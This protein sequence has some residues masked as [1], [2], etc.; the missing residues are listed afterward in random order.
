MFAKWWI[1]TCHAFP[2][3]TNV[4]SQEK[5]TIPGIDKSDLSSYWMYTGSQQMFLDAL[6][7]GSFST[8]AL[9]EFNHPSSRLAPRT[10][11]CRSC[12][13]QLWQ[14]WRWLSLQHRCEHWSRA[15]HNDW[16]R[17]WPTWMPRILQVPG[18]KHLQTKSRMRC[19]LCRSVS[20]LDE[21]LTIWFDNLAIW[22]Y[23]VLYFCYFV[24][25]CLAIDALLQRGKL[26][27]YTMSTY[28]TVRNLCSIWEAG[29]RVDEE[30]FM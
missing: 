23:L 13:L 20:R 9:P 3:G 12:H 16:W 30:F 17:W 27:S 8:Q 15:W 19:N 6:R 2:R 14:R 4:M 7:V 24:L 21:F 1:K 11:S 26:G 5:T 28:E 25:T 22:V 18:L 29:R 10:T